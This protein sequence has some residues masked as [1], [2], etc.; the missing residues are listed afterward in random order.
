MNGINLLKYHDKSFSDIHRLMNGEIEDELFSMLVLSGE[1][2]QSTASVRKLFSPVYAVALLLTLCAG[3][4]AYFYYQTGTKT[5]ELIKPVKENAVVAPVVEAQPKN[6]LEREGYVKIGEILFLN[7]EDIVTPVVIESDYVEP[8]KTDLAFVESQA[9]EV[10]SLNVDTEPPPRKEPIKRGTYVAVG[11]AAGREIQQ[12][13]R[14]IASK[15]DIKKP[16]TTVNS[17]AVSVKPELPKSVAPQVKKKEETKK[18]ST[19][20]VRVVQP[21]NVQTGVASKIK[22][23]QTTN[24]PP[25]KYSVE[26]Y[27]LSSGKRYSVLTNAEKLGFETTQK[28]VEQGENSVWRVYKLVPGAKMQVAGRGVEFV[29]DL[30]TQEQ[31]LEFVRKNNIPAA[32]KQ[33]KI[34]NS[35][36]NVAVCCM[37]ADEAKKFAERNRAEGV[38]FKILPV[39]E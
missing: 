21:A 10:K 4:A 35:V 36:Y 1:N 33:V 5:A 9:V 17:T 26:F 12:D 24:I 32:I 28:L 37:S 14:N 7:D 6:R 39:V 31:A 2:E 29:A 38:S 23:Q 34:E 20:E 27:G 11:N 30:P 15:S 3:G 25:K 22:S 18:Q 13:N 16:V 8:E 19:T